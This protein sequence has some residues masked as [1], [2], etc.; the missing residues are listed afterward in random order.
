MPRLYFPPSQT[1]TR[2]DNVFV[3]VDA[4]TKAYG[5]TV[6]LSSDNHICLAMSKNC[7]APTKTVTLPRLELMAA[8]TATRLIRFVLSLIPHDKQQVKVYFWTDSQIVLHWVNKGTNCMPFICNQ[9][10]EITEA[11]PDSTWTFTP[12]SDNLTDLLTRGLSAG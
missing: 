2:T 8:V 7:V 6:Y 12:S 5:T 10:K 9:V 3:F 11:F 4:C 1:G